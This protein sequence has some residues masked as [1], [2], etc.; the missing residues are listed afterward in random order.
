MEEQEFE[1]QE[2][3]SYQIV[4]EESVRIALMLGLLTLACNGFA[5]AVATWRSYDE[6]PAL[7]ENWKFIQHDN[8]TDQ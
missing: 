5:L 6:Q 2:H 4:L 1:Q 3:G 8:L 7:M